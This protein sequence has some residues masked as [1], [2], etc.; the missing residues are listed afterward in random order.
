MYHAKSIF[1][2]AYLQTSENEFNSY[3]QCKLFMQFVTNQYQ[4]K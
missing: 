2:I 4:S 3:F 1:Y